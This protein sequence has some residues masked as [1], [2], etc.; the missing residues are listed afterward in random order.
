MQAE[1]R[2]P[3]LLE[4]FA[5][6]QPILYNVLQILDCKVRKK[7]GIQYHYSLSRTIKVALYT[8]TLYYI[9]RNLKR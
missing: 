5:E 8:I 3:S 6:A 2:T 4:R 9:V 7:I 1:G